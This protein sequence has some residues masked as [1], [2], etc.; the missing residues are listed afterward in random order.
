MHAAVRVRLGLVM[1]TALAWLAPAAAGDS[2]AVYRCV[3]RA[4]RVAYQDF[5][6]PAKA[7]QRLLHLPAAPAP[8]AT[9]ASVAP[10]ADAAPAQPIPEPPRPQAR[11]QPEPPPLPMLFAC[12][13]ATNGKLYHTEHPRPPYLA[14]FGILGAVQAPLAQ[15]YGAGTGS[16]LSAPELSG[17]TVSPNLIGG[18]Y[19]WVEDP[20]RRLSARE[21]CEVLREQQDENKAALRTAYRGER[22]PL[23]RRREA[24]AA[25]LK[26]CSD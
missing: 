10:P 12:V 9:T 4:G 19:V 18:N 2:D 16:H 1:L 13:N 3:D 7:Q 25:K 14:P 15:V 21:T 20:C 22:K 24:L 5:P 26:G 11:P 23:Q 17:N 6:C 8:A